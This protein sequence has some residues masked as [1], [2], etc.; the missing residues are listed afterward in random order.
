VSSVIVRSRALRRLP[1]PLRRVRRPLLGGEGR[2]LSI[3]A[4]G[5]REAHRARDRR[6]PV[7][8]HPHADRDSTRWITPTASTK[9]RTEADRLTRQVASPT[10]PSGPFAPRRRP[11]RIAHTGP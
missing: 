11:K 1:V 5:Q 8:P 9:G 6:A 7:P 10:A 4:R 3:A 2:L